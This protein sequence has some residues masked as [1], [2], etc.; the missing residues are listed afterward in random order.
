MPSGGFLWAGMGGGSSMGIET[1]VTADL[2]AARDAHAHPQS[3]PEGAPDPG[4]L[5][6]PNH[7]RASRPAGHQRAGELWR[8]QTARHRALVGEP[9]PRCGALAVELDL[10]GYAC[11][12]PGCGWRPAVKITSRGIEDE[13]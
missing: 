11:R 6:G 13:A 7:L 5:R 12:A 2:R 9:C 1:D 8:E 10:D 4:A 3:R